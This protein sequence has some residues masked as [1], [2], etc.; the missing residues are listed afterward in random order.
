MKERK[1]LLPRSLRKRIR[2][3]KA[4]LRREFG[5]HSSQYKDFCASIEGLRKQKAVAQGARQ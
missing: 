5:E 1:M 4:A 3:Q 2:S